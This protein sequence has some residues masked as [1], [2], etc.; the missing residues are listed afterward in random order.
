MVKFTIPLNPI[1]KKN[2]QRV[3]PNKGRYIPVPSK[4]FS[5]Y[6]KQ[7][8]GYMPKVDTPISDYVNIKALYYLGARRKTDLTNLNEALHDVLVHYQV[9]EDDNNLCVGAT[10]GSRVLYDKDNP[11]TEVEITVLEEEQAWK[12]KSQTK[13]RKMGST[14]K[15]EQKTGSEMFKN[16]LQEIGITT[17]EFVALPKRQRQFIIDNFK[18]NSG[19]QR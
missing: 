6:Q 18:A 16:Y 8:E 9:I 14:V 3:I 10:D 4:Q 15:S 11:R 12:P 1:T 7:C 19:Y 5:E 13:S 17:K 2:S